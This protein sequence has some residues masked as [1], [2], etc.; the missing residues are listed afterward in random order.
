M[1]GFSLF[2]SDLAQISSTSVSP[3]FTQSPSPTWHWIG[4][5]DSTWFSLWVN[6]DVAVGA[7]GAT[8]ISRNWAFPSNLLKSDLK[9]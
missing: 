9:I 1:L 4:K 3:G 8:V 5:I 2:G 6:L 7:M